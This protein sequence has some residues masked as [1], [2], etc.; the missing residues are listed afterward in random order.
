MK[1]YDFDTDD[2]PAQPQPQPQQ[3]QQQ[4]IPAQDLHAKPPLLEPVAV[5]S[6][7]KPVIPVP[8]NA[9]PAG[10]TSSARLMAPVRRKQQAQPSI[11]QSSLP[12]QIQA[13]PV[14]VVS[15]PHAQSPAQASPPVIPLKNSVVPAGK[16]GRIDDEYDPNKPNEYE[17]C[18]I[19]AKRRRIEARREKKLQLA[20]SRA[21]SL[22]ASE[23]P[24]VDAVAKSSEKVVENPQN[25]AESDGEDSE[26]V[27]GVP[28]DAT[29]L[30][31]S[32]ATAPIAASAA[33]ANMQVDSGDDAYKR[34]MA[35]SS[36][37]AAVIAQSS[38]DD[39]YL[40]RA[41]MS[42]SDDRTSRSHAA[43][44]ESRVILLLNMVGPGEVDED[45]EEETASEC[46]KFGRVVNVK[47]FEAKVGPNIQQDEAVRIF[48]KFEEVDAAREALSK[49]DGRFFGRRAIRATF[50][51]ELQFNSGNL[52]P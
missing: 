29:L 22:A 24:S 11:H 36:T 10:W 45:L 38:G 51:D 21:L 47:I 39:A 8:T 12:Q 5:R 16:Q 33:L 34:R 44:K 7:K 52:R 14:V 15:V 2:A 40:Q 49:M 35:M 19:E 41:Q 30:Q 31:K 1:L 20:Q 50:F 28:L 13:K 23:R 37:A 18:K 26:D 9:F 48:V 3:V 25:R 6:A 4:Q 46:S 27:D 32:S 42:R 43:V 17:E